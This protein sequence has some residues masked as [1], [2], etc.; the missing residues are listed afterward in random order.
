MLPKISNVNGNFLLQGINVGFSHS[1][2]I[3]LLLVAKHALDQD[4]V[5]LSIA[6]LRTV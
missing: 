2:V 5:Q 1:R 3:L 4:V 6:A